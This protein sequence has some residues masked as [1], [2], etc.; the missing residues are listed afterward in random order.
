MDLLHISNLLCYEYYTFYSLH[1]Y[2]AHPLHS[3]PRNL[4][5]Y[6]TSSI[7][8]TLSGHNSYGTSNYYQHV[9]LRLCTLLGTLGCSI[10]MGSVVDRCSTRGFDCYV[11]TI[12][13]VSLFSLA[14]PIM[15]VH[16]YPFSVIRI[17]SL[18]YVPANAR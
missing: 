13:Y 9:C 8:I 17:C 5:R 11:S 16:P 3:L 15:P 18:Q 14:F 10:R 7:S 6:D 4:G 12:R 2:I 1:Y